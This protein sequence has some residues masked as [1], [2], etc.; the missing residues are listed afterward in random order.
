MRLSWNKIIFLHNDKSGFTL[1]EFL[2]VIAIIAIMG[3]IALVAFNPPYHFAQARNSQRTSNVN[4]ILGAIHQYAVDNTGS[5][6]SAI[7]TSVTEICTTGGSCAGL[8]D[9]SVLT[10]TEKY[11]VTMPLDPSCPTGCAANGVGYTV[12]KS[13]NGRVTIAA[14]DAELSETISVTR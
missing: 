12:V 1:F 8:I 3:T 7:T 5:L 6:P 9:L 2:I 11:L 13:A 10:A 4:S 14:P